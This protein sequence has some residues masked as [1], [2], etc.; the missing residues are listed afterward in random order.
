MKNLSKTLTF[1]LTAL[2]LS[3]FIYHTINGE[4]GIIKL[5][6]IEDELNKKQK[7]LDN[8][9]IE[10]Q[11]LENHVK[12]LQENSYDIDYV[13]ELARDYFGL[14]ANGEKIIVIENENKSQSKSIKK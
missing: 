1:I 3:Y 11:I 8:L 6:Q 10:K 13:D 2:I 5:L 14:V 7:T 12:L 4:R 9:K